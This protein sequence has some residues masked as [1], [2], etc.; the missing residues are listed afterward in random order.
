M[1]GYSKV[2]DNRVKN[3]LK[4]TGVSTSS[5]PVSTRNPRSPSVP[6]APIAGPSFPSFLAFGASVVMGPPHSE[7]ACFA[8]NLAVQGRASELFNWKVAGPDL[9]GG[10]G[11]ILR[12]RVK[13]LSTRW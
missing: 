10:Q 11:A 7:S 4:A 8:L 3:A 12:L 2:T 9:G 1:F 5:T 6:F 13:V